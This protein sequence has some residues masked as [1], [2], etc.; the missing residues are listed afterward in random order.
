MVAIVRGL[1]FAA[2]WAILF[3]A[4]SPQVRAQNRPAEIQRLNA[5]L[6]T[7][8]DRD[9][10][11]SLMRQ[12]QAALVDLLRAGGTEA[13][14]GLGLTPEESS[15]IA[16]AAPEAA[17]LIESQ[18]VFDGELD[19]VVEDDFSNRRDLD[20]LLPALELRRACRDS[21]QHQ[22]AGAP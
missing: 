20:P 1:R 11:V 5:A 15:R 4:F 9:A 18:G 19:E 17:T 2:V 6:G 3:F 21:E 7:A 12:R 8:Q 16:A 22:P 14:A 10:I 13:A